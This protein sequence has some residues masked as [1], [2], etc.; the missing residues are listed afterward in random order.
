V[1]TKRLR[2]I[3][4]QARFNHLSPRQ[5]FVQLVDQPRDGGMLFERFSDFSRVRRLIFCQQ[6]KDDLLF[7][8]EMSLQIAFS[9]VGEPG[10]GFSKA[11]LIVARSDLI[12]V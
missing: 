2:E 8:R 12:Q 10:G 5:F 11:G 3:G 1:A 4:E 7:L 6:L 9:E